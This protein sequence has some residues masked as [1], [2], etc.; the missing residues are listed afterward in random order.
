MK[1]V[2]FLCVFEIDLIRR[3][4]CG[5]SRSFLRCH[6]RSSWHSV[7]FLPV[8]V[9]FFAGLLAYTGINLTVRFNRQRFAKVSRGRTS[10]ESI[11]YLRPRTIVAL[12]VA[13][14]SRY[15]LC[16]DTNNKK[17]LRF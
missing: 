11:R 3:S 10:D 5:N 6:R 12:I 1:Q 15:T 16:T 4:V 8:L 14:S 9:L 17:F 7:G 13:R 2:Y